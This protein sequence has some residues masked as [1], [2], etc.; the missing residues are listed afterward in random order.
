MSNNAGLRCPAIASAQLHRQHGFRHI[1]ANNR[2][3]TLYATRLI[4]ALEG[5]I[6]QKQL[7]TLVDRYLTTKYG[8]HLS[9]DLLQ[10]KRELSTL[11]ETDQLLH[12]L[13]WN[14]RALSIIHDIFDHPDYDIPEDLLEYSWEEVATPRDTSNRSYILVTES[15]VT[16]QR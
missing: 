8:G 1:S 14:P 3:S 6:Y 10:I 11:L 13:N 16:P 5:S 9:S 7:S 2:E 12:F 4:L 15:K